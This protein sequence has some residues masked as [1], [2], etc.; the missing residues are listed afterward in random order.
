MSF[1]LSTKSTVFLSI[2]TLIHICTSLLPNIGEPIDAF[3]AVFFYYSIGY[4]SIGYFFLLQ[5]LSLIPILPMA[6][7]FVIIIRNFL[8]HNT[9]PERVEY[10]LNMC[11]VPVISIFGIIFIY[12]AIIGSLFFWKG[13]IKKYKLLEKL[14]LF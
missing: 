9:P 13:F 6:P 14:R 7:S 8:A 11:S 3:F 4:I 10:F 2:L 12:I 1:F 5:T